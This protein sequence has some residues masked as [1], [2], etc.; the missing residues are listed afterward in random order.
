MY[1][2]L[3]LFI[4]VIIY[5]LFKNKREGFEFKPEKMESSLQ[6]FQQKDITNDEKD[7]LMLTFGKEIYSAYKLLKIDSMKN[8]L[9]SYCLIY[10]HGGIFINDS[11][12]K[13][14]DKS[15]FNKD[16]LIVVPDLKY[17][18]FN[19]WIFSSAS[20]NNPVLKNI[21]DICIKRIIENQV[22]KEEYIDYIT[23]DQCFTD[24]I[25]QYLSNNNKIIYTN[26]NDY[27]QYKNKLFTVVDSREFHKNNIEPI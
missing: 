12:Y 26:V 17:N 3:F 6:V 7:K 24:G 1:F 2:L 8:H 5:I 10:K 20:P 13:I 15:I 27:V 21:I 16:G 25:L 22:I 18:L 14:K 19:N 4:I 23:G 11:K 9:W